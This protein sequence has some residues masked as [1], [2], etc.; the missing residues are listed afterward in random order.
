MLSHITPTSLPWEQSSGFEYLHK[1]LG[2]RRDASVPSQYM[3][4]NKMAPVP[5]P[6]VTVLVYDLN[7]NTPVKF[8]EIAKQLEEMTKYLYMCS[9]TVQLNKFP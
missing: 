4:S 5:R 9:S 6:N 2:A 8:I 7:T 3:S 1:Q